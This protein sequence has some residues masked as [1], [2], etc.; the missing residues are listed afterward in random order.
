MLRERLKNG[1]KP[2]SPRLFVFNTCRQFIR[3]MP[4]LP[5]DEIDINDVDRAAEGH[6]GDAGVRPRD[7]RKN[8][9][10]AA[11]PGVAFPAEQGDSES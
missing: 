1:M 10:S 8:A 11:A 6:V 2:D 9:G 7:R 3:M 5:R 4:V